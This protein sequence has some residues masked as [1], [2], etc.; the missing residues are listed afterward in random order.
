MKAYLWSI[1]GPPPTATPSKWRRFIDRHLPSMIIYL[2]VLTLV[3]VV[4]FPH[5]AVTVPSG[6]VGLLW[7]RFG[8]GTVLDPRQLRSSLVYLGTTVPVRSETATMTETYNAISSDGVSLAATMNV[9]FRLSVML[10]PHQALAKL[11]GLT[12]AANFSS[13]TPSRINTLP[14]VYS[15]AQEIQRQNPWPCEAAG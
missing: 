13:L 1:D 2:M 10:S 6:H 8:F 5:F 7:K 9:R 14:A 15:T 3:T 11:S 4:L 12:S